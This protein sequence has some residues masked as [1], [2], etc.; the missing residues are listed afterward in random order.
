IYRAW[1]SFGDKVAAAQLATMLLGFV[2]LLL[3]M[4]RISRGK[5]SYENKSTRQDSG[6]KIT[7][8]GLK[9][10]GASLFCA[11]PLG[12]GFLLPVIVLITMALRVDAGFSISRYFDL[13]INTVTLGGITAL[14]AAFL[15]L[16]VV[17]AIRM[18]PLHKPL[19]IA[20]RMSGLGYAIPG[21]IIAVGVLIPFAWFDNQLD[22]FF[23][24]TF[25]ISTGLVLTGS[26]VALVFAYL[27]RFLS[28]S[29]QTIEAGFA[30]VN[31]S[32]DSAAR[33]LGAS[34]NRLLKDVHFPL[35][36][37]SLLTAFLMVFVDV[38]KELPATLIMR[39]FNFDTLAVVAHN[40]ASDERLAEAAVPA[41]TIVVVGMLPVLLLSRMI[42]GSAKIK[43]A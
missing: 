8:T 20:G 37:V 41:L 31:P 2:V 5:S 21:S 9:A 23:R 13:I 4:E 24:S 42:V 11:V 7:L 14:L 28:V 39:P 22:G 25:G 43:K 29:M 32:L 34:K 40:F 38:M 10:W 16:M 19:A 15:G 6:E 36:K 17:F 3:A 1:F 27:V 26:I 12:F 30:Q 33:S 18:H 35:L